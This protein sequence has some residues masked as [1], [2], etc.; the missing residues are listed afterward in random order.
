MLDTTN[1][2]ATSRQLHCSILLFIVLFEGRIEV[3]QLAARQSFDI[4]IFYIS[5]C[6]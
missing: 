2:F 3:L 1:R 5:I 4:L 6:S